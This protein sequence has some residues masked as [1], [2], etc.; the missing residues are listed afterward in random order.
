[1]SS[2]R[3]GYSVYINYPI[4]RNEDEKGITVKFVSNMIRTFPQLNDAIQMAR[5]Q[6]L[7]PND[8]VYVINQR[9][10]ST[11]FYRGVIRSEKV[12]MLLC[13]T[14]EEVERFYND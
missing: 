6:R 14:D 11:L 5:S 3:P 12:K 1:M 10:N 13:T 4:R 8:S 2:T 7:R 9:T